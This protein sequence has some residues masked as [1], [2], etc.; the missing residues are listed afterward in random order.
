LYKFY[1]QKLGVASSVVITA[2]TSNSVADELKLGVANTGVE[3]VGTST[4]SFLMF[5]SGSIKLDQPIEMS[6]HR[7]GRQATSYI[8]KKKVVEGELGM[9]A[10]VSASTLSLDAPVSS[11]LECIFGTKSTSGSEISFTMASLPT[12]YVS[13]LNCSNVHNSAGN[14]VFAKSWSITFPGDG[15]AEIKIPIKGRDL[16]YAGIARASALVNAS[17]NFVCETGEGGSFEA[18]G[19]VMVV[20]ADGRTVV[21]GG[22]GALYVSSV[23]TDTVVLSAVVTCADESFLVPFNPYLLGAIAANESILTDLEGSVSFDGGST[24]IEEIVS[25][26]IAVDPKYSELD[27]YYGSD[28]NRGYMA[29]DRAEIK[30]SVEMNLSASQFKKIIAMKSF[31]SFSMKLIL[32]PAAG[33]RMEIVCPKVVY[34]VPAIDI[35]D[36]GFVA[37]KFEGVAFQSAAGL[38]DAIT[39]SYK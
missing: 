2:A 15:P 34:N 25:A 1:S 30:V 5:K 38:L 21:A 36:S 8:K 17:A 11:L 23:S 14:G 26:E 9:Y 20:D 39:V 28:G 4:S 13:I 37:V 12:R 22:D 32:G 3:A 35:P 27:N 29:A 7:S 16:K 31:T 19:R 6:A 33:R 24:S 18:G 10:C